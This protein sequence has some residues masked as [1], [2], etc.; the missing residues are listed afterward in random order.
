MNF[1]YTLIISLLFSIH[2]LSAQK[3]FVIIGDSLT[4]GYGIAKESAFPHLLENLISNYKIINAGIS[5]STSASAMSR[6]KWTLKSKPDAILIA[7]GGN[8]G[9]RGL[10][11][12]ELSKNLTGAIKEIKKTQTKVMLAGIQAPP[13]YGAQYT[14]DFKNIF[15]QI[16]KE[17]KIPLYPFLLEGV[18]G[19]PRLNL[20]DGIHPNEE[21]HK[22]IAEKILPF[23]KKELP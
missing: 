23:I 16:A 3:T 12:K 5:G 1:T 2:A 14:K 19:N 22:V 10:S 18:A 17:Q 11:I 21:G 6:V 15:S 8:D 20:P 4:E 7:L 13:N 9:L